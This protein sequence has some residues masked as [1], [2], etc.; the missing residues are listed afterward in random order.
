MDFPTYIAAD[1]GKR[2]GRMLSAGGVVVTVRSKATGEHITVRLASRFKNYSGSGK[3]WE[4]V[5][6]SNATHIFFSV[7]NAGPGWDDKIGTFY[8]KSGKF[9]EDKNADAARVWAA[10]AVMNWLNG[11]AS[12][13]K[14]EY[15]ESNECGRCGRQLT[16]PVSID[17]G[18]GPECYSKITGSKHQVKNKED[19]T[20]EE[21]IEAI[22]TGWPG[23]I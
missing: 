3:K 9:F 5:G 4:A 6:P 10:A 2:A 18:I 14:A 17:R 21:E 13:D 15:Y 11:D 22:A 1:P 12:E 20:D 8:P 19:Q 7:P 23:A 16:D